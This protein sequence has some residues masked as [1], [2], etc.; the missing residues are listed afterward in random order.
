MSGDHL[1]KAP[2]FPKLKWDCVD[3]ID[4]NPD[5][6]PGDEVEYETCEA[7]GRY[8]VRFVHCLVHDEWDDEIRVG[9]LCAE[10]LTRDRV[11]P[12]RRE[13]ELRKRAAARARWTT[14]RWRRSAKGNLYLKAKGHRIVVMPSRFVE[15]WTFS[16]DGIFSRRTFPDELAAKRASYDG[17]E[18]M[19]RM[20]EDD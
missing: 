20:A 8:P 10:K 14:R 16:A 2:G 18:Y 19:R 1:W 11:N 3:V 17:Y 15:G 5:E 9:C 12:R 7:C 13:D 6:L 4:L